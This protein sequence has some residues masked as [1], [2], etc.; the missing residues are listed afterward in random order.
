MKILREETSKEKLP[1]SFLT[2]FMSKGW[3]EVGYLK[4]AIKAIGTDFSETAKVEEIMQ[5]LI[6]AYLICIGQ[7]ELY[8]EDK[9][10]VEYPEDEPKPKLAEPAKTVIEEEPKEIPDTIIKPESMTV[11]V[12]NFGTMPAEGD[13][14]DYKIDDSALDD[15]KADIDTRREIADF[16][17]DFDEPDMS[18][19]RLTDDELYGQED[20]ELEQA[21]LRN[22]LRG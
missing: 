8:L 18:Q 15:A 11:G 3:E 9:N 21:K 19:P 13:F 1:V 16:F 12:D 14:D 20:S 22:Q 2:D 4:E 7:I 17:V 5:D 10:Y 6:D